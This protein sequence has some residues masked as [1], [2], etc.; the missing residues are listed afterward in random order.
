VKSQL[1]AITIAAMAMLMLS[2]C[3]PQQQVR[4]PFLE[5]FYNS[6]VSETASKDIPV[7]I[8]KL[9][10]ALTTRRPQEEVSARRLRLAELYVHPYNKNQNCPGA[11]DETIL[12]LEA[13]QRTNWP[14]S[15]HAEYVHR[16]LKAQ[17]MV[18]NACA[19]PPKAKVNSCPAP[20]VIVKNSPKAGVLEKM[21]EDLKQCQDN[22][23]RLQNLE[24]NM[25]L[26]RRS[27]K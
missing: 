6:L 23:K 5:G 9:K 15:E 18:R 11:Y 21:T 25:E 8:D 7:E 16:L 1:R 10:R 13:A 20:K 19:T 4:E 22:M 2:A 17:G 14:A 24:I 27:I 12:S 26:K 3:I